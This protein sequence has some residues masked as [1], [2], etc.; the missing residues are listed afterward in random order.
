[1]ELKC[2]CG[3]KFFNN[4]SFAQHRRCCKNIKVDSL[5]VEYDSGLSINEL[6]DK[7]KLPRVFIQNNIDARTLSDANKIA[8]EKYPEKFKHTDTTKEK[9]RKA[10]FDYLKKR[11]GNTPWD[12]R[13]RGEMSYLENW[14]KEDVILKY[15]LQEKYD[16]VYNYAEYPFFLDFAFTNIKLAVELDGKCHFKNGNERIQHDIDRDKKL[17]EQGWTMYRIRYD[18]I[19]AVTIEAFLKFLENTHVIESKIYGDN[20]YKYA[21]I[22]KPKE[23]K[24]KV[25]V[26]LKEKYKERQIKYVDLLMKSE[27]DFFTHGWVVQAAKIINQKPQKVNKWMKKIMPDFYEKCFK[28]KI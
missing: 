6:V 7:H 2:K 13:Q 10:R 1:M 22:K 26:D 27:I 11:I 3:R 9:I 8:H 24:R 5:Q 21:E 23:K 4:N 14:F 19:N 12:K 17:V 28:R 18:Q 20:L 25:Q 16:I 15:K